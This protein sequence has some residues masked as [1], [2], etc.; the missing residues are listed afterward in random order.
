MPNRLKGRGQTKSDPTGPPGWEL[1]RGLLPLLKKIIITETRSKVKSLFERGTVA[2]PHRRELMM[3]RSQSQQ[4]NSRLIKPP[5]HPKYTMRIGNWNVRTLYR[6]GNI[7]QV[8]REMTKRGIEVM[9]ISETLDGTRNNATCRGQN[10]HLLW[11]R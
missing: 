2:V 10:H 11:K 8:A 3:Y 7:A 1:S 9:G 4:D 6:S 5:I